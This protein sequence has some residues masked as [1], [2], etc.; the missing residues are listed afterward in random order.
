MNAINQILSYIGKL[1][2]WIY[3]IQPWEQALRVRAGKKV[4]RISAG[5]HFRIPF[6]DAVYMQSIRKRACGTGA[7]TV[8]TK[9]GK[10]ITFSGSIRY[11]IENIENMYMNVYNVSDTVQQEVQG[12]IVK[13]VIN[14]R[15]EDCNAYMLQKHIEDTLDLS[16]YGFADVDFFLTDF[17]VVKTFRL[18]NGDIGSHYEDYVNM[19]RASHGTVPNPE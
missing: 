6:I 7:Q 16:Q 13:Y 2:T 19:N 11:R 4:K 9:D 3:V 14:K 5:I 17:A 1:F 18:I 10:T 12:A 15:L 8:T